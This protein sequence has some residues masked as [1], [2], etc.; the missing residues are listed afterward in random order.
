MTARLVAVGVL[1]CLVGQGIAGQSN[2]F[3]PITDAALL[4]PD[5]DD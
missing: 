5:P 4:N 3:K 2:A 1:L